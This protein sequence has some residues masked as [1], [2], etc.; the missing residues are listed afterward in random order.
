MTSSY[1]NVYHKHST[2]ISI[3]PGTSI[4]TLVKVK[5]FHTQTRY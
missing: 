5:L 1:F 2:I 3:N 4:E